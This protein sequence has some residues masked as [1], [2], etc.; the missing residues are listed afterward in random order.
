MNLSGWVGFMLTRGQKATMIDADRL[1]GLR[2][3][4]EHTLPPRSDH[5]WFASYEEAELGP[6]SSE[7]SR[8]GLW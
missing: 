4:A 6:S 5:H 2:S 7:R 8:N 3:M 1:A